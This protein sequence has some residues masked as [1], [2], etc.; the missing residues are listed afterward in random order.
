MVVAY[1]EFEPYSL[2]YLCVILNATLQ[3]YAI[4][5]FRQDFWILNKQE[6][7]SAECSNMSP[8]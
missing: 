2:E 6:Q 8:Y 4:V 7:L 1:V 5:T 3:I